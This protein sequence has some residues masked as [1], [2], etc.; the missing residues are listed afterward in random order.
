MRGPSAPQIK[1]LYKGMSAPLVGVTP[2]FAV[3]FWAYDVAK[4]MIKSA[5]GIDANTNLSLVNIGIAGGLAAI[6]TTVPGTLAPFENGCVC[7]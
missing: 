7:V 6:P 4:K 2:I 1:G 5:L 3:N